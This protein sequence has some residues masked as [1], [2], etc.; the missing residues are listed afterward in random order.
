MRPRAGRVQVATGLWLTTLFVAVL[1]G[2]WG[3]VELGELCLV[4]CDFAGRADRAFWCC[5]LGRAVGLSTRGG[6]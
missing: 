2:G 1:S 5:E 6:L 4:R 3:V